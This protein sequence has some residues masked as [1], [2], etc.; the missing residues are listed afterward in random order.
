MDFIPEDVWTILAVAFAGLIL[1][2]GVRIMRKGGHIRFGKLEIEADA[3]TCIEDP[4]EDKES[5]A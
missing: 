5:V 3:P 1:L 2:T 4:K